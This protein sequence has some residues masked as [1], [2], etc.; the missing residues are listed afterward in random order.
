MS[1]TQRFEATF[2]LIPQSLQRTKL[3]EKIDLAR[4]VWNHV[5]AEH[6]KALQAEPAH[7]SPGTPVRAAIDQRGYRFSVGK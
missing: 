7:A 2:T 1:E 4:Q 6:F 5:D 3:T